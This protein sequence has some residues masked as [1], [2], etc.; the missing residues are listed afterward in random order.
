[1]GGNRFN[2]LVRA[3][4]G[5]PASEIGR[6]GTSAATLALVPAGAPRGFY[7]PANKL[8]PRFGFAYD[9]WGNGKTSIR[10][11]FGMYYDKVEG[12]LI[13]SQVNLPPFI[14]T[15]PF[16]ALVANV[17]P[18]PNAN[19]NTLRR[20]KGY[21]SIA[22]RLSDATSTYNGLQLYAVKRKGDLELTAAY[23][24]S[25]NLTDTSGNGDGLD[26]GEDP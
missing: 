16:D 24:W 3:G 26:V 12:N 17:A 11:G 18:G 13:F 2:G 4:T 20:Y 5:I 23:T 6:V 14:S 10:G 8:A 7:N 21:T 22:Y 19:L 25:R 15:P 9:P 1:K